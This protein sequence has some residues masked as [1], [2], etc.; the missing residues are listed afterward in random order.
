MFLFCRLEF[1]VVKFWSFYVFIEVRV[2]F[3]NVKCKNIISK[4]KNQIALSWL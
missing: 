1:C 3:H 2:D 4:L